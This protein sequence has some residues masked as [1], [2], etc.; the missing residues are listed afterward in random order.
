[1]KG[2]VNDA[3]SYTKDMTDEMIL[4]TTTFDIICKKECEIITGCQQN[5]NRISMKNE[6]CKIDIE[7]VNLIYLCTTFKIQSTKLYTYL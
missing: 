2:E 3:I 1:M 7:K 6:E 4:A 5:F